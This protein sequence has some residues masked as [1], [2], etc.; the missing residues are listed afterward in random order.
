MK[1]LVKGKCRKLLSIFLV[2]VI[3]LSFSSTQGV[4]AD[5]FLNN[6]DESKQNL[7]QEAAEKEAENRQ[8]KEG[9]HA[10][11]P[12]EK[13][14]LEDQT[15][16]A[17]RELEEKKASSPNPD[18]GELSQRN[19]GMRNQVMGTRSQQTYNLNADGTVTAV[20]D[21]EAKTITVS[22]NATISHE[23]WF[24][25][26]EA[27]DLRGE[28]VADAVR[29]YTYYWDQEKTSDITL[30]VGPGVKF[31]RRSDHMFAKYGGEIDL[32]PG[33]DASNIAY[34]N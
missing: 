20:Y 1:R 33:V 8:E 32:D 12:I 19:A 5:D 26:M 14:E 27:F 16:E 11:K 17:D 7:L 22:G 13:P 9:V 30:K 2:L 29:E 6:T 34:A 28:W 10:P 18:R 31:P 4:F 15:E 24:E 21:S 23:L 3:T 25:M